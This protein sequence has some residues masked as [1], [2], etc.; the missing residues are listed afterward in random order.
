LEP[1]LKKKMD[2]HYIQMVPCESIDFHQFKATNDYGEEGIYYSLITSLGNA[3]CP[4]DGIIE[5]KGLIG[6]NMFITPKHDM[7]TS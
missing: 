5:Y 6:T 1:E 3:L 2:T 7:I 4:E